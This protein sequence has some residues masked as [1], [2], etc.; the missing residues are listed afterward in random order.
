MVGHTGDS[1]TPGDEENPD[2]LPK[3]R[4]GYPEIHLMTCSVIF[5]AMLLSPGY[6][7]ELLKVSVSVCCFSVFAC[8]S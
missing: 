1:K 4:A 8:I 7:S 2:A 3:R 5:V 6:F